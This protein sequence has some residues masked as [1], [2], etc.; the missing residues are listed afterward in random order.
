MGAFL[1]PFFIG[2]VVGF[3]IGVLVMYLLFK[4][5][6][7]DPYW[8]EPLGQWVKMPADCPGNLDGFDVI[9]NPT[10]VHV[11]GIWRN[12]GNVAPDTNI[13]FVAGE[14]E[15]TLRLQYLNNGQP[16]DLSPKSWL[17]VETGPGLKWE[18]DSPGAFRGTLKRT[19]NTPGTSTVKFILMGY[20]RSKRHS[21]TV[22]KYGGD[23]TINVTL[24]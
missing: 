23:T 16:K 14:T 17:E 22:S 9:Q 3:L 13:Q 15:K 24:S 10:L 8:C 1:L 6:A 2:L 11:R 4:G 12:S 20:V 5:K 19:D 18:P 21:T 7:S